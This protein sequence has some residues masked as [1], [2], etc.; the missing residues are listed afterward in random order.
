MPKGGKG[1]VQFA[2]PTGTTRV[3][4][5]AVNAEADFK[6]VIGAPFTVTV[7]KL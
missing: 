1:S 5:V 2:V 7:K 6:G 3:T 4:I